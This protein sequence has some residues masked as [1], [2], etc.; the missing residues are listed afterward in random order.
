MKAT[1]KITLKKSKYKNK[2][3]Q[4]TA[5]IC[6]EIHVRKLTLNINV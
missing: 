5:C 6:G 1:E 2:Q 4:N 3:K